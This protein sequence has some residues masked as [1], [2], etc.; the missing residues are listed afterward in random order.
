CVA[1]DAPGQRMAVTDLDNRRIRII[2]MKTQRVTLAAGNGERGVPK[3]GADAKNAPLVDPRAACF[4][5]NG[6]LYILERGGHALRVV[7][8]EGKIRTV[9]GVSG[10]A[11]NSGDGGDALT[12]TLNG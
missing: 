7:D 6:N 4:D 12:A 10:K 3:D 1:L 9:V 11:G 8:G 5:R 2:D